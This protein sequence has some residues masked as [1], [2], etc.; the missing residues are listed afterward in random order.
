MVSNLTCPNCRQPIT[1]ETEVCPHC[2]T[3]IRGDVPQRYITNELEKSLPDVVKQFDATANN[4]IAIA[5]GVSGLYA[6]A[7]FAGKVTT[8]GVV[9][10]AL[11]YTLPLCFLLV[12]IIS[13]VRV[14]YPEG[15]YQESNYRTLIKEKQRRLQFSSIFL[16]VALGILIVGVFVYLL[17]PH[18]AIP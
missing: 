15:Y 10:T 4:N 16:Q 3:R 14:Y 17:L 1:L 9:F 12:A 5:G 7:I 13:A 18:P 2:G 11:L 8:L 6:S